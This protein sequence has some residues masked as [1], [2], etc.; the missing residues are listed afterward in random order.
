MEK[1]VGEDEIKGLDEEIDSAV[2]RLFV[3]KK[4]GMRESLT[5]EPPPSRPSLETVKSVDYGSP[6]PSSPEPPSSIKSF[7][8]METQLL[9]LEWEITKE[10]IE[11][12]KEEVLSLK[13]SLK[14]RPDIVSILNLM[15]KVLIHMT[16]NVENIPP[17]QIKFLLD[18]KET[19]KLLMRKET[20]GEI[21]IYKQLTLGGIEARFLSLEGLEVAKAK[22]PSISANEEKDKLEVPKLWKDQIEG[23]Q[24]KMNLF[25]EKMDEIL[26]KVNQ[27]MSRMGQAT[28][29]P[30]EE[31][32]EEKPLPVDITVFIIY[33]KLM[34]IESHKIFKL[35]KI[36]DAFLSKYLSKQKI[37]LKDFEIKMVDLR[38]IFPLEN[39]ERKGEKQLLA[40]KEG[41]EYRGLIVDQV[42]KKISAQLETSRGYSEY[43]S[44][45]VR[46]TYHGEPVGIPIL[47]LKKI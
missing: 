3:E 6:V 4:S 29:I 7:E 8:K 25:S 23:I 32:M 43:F 21:S 31:L 13:E 40:L 41:G 12:T 42:L 24:K 19:I 30:R 47:D 2:D 34:G 27:H 28:K 10:N 16:K 1:M 5:M 46:S 18:S 39:R 45:M 26:N 15:G 35:F 9:S 17:P 14:E 33:E 38:K 37:Q 20:E 22:K 36:P 11:K 44:E